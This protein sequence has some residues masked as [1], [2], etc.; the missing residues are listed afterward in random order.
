MNKILRVS[1]EDLDVT[2]E[3]GVTRQQLN[4]ALNNT[5]LTFYVDRWRVDA[6]RHGCDRASGTTTV[7]YGTMRETVLALTVVLADGRIIHRHARPQVIAGYDLTRLFV[8]SEGT[9]GII[10]E[11][12]LRVYPQPEQ[13]PRSLLVPER[14]K[15]VKT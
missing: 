6:G 5:G 9:L 14:R 15:R 1:A 12:T 4:K 11:L 7:R 13:C 10:T 8:G 3:P 2:V